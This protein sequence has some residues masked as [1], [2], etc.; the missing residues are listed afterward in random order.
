MPAAAVLL[1]DL[2]RDFLAGPGARLPVRD[3]DA[4]RVIDA[5]NAVL[6]G[7]AF[8]GSL[9][10]AVVNRFPASDRIANF[11]RNRAALE[12]SPGAEPDERVALR[13]EVNVFSKQRA[14]AFSNPALAR[15][16]DANGVTELVVLGVFA[17]G[18]VRATAL[19]A[20]RRGYRVTVPLDAIGTSSRLRH[21]FA[22]WS[23]HR[24][25]VELPP[26][27]RPAPA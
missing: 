15:Y 18:C 6:R 12:G 4:Q 25:G 11:F 26:S 7:T 20:R 8:P 1:M 22:A 2:Q 5:A 23:L 14:S 21:R 16:L 27:W 13:P 19:D 3:E 9:P 10:V 24:A 17:E